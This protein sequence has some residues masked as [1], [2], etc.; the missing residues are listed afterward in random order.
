LALYSLW[1]GQP[2]G[3]EEYL[4]ES[5]SYFSVLDRKYNQYMLQGK[6]VPPS[7]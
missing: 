6:Q 7:L 1:Q 4:F 3:E 5:S 2:L